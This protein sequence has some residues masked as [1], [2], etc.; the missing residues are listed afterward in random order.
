MMSMEHLAKYDWQSGDRGRPPSPTAQCKMKVLTVN[1]TQ[2]QYNAIVA[3]REEGLSPSIS[4]AVRD[5]VD[6]WLIKHHHPIY[7]KEG[8][9]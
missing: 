2:R 6:D 8:Q 9:P 4:E 3:C 1:L 5:A 7:Y